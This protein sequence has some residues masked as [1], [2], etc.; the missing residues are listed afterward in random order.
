[1]PLVSCLMNVYNGEKYIRE[2]VDS[3]LNQT[4]SDFE[5]III[6]DGSTDQTLQILQSY[7]DSRIKVFKNGKNLGIS[8]SRNRG[9]KKVSGKYIA[10]LD[11]DDISL[12]HRFMTQLNYMENHPEIDVCGSAAEVFGNTSR[13]TEPLPTHDE[14][15]AGFLE[16]CRLLYSS[17]FIRRQTV[18]D[19]N[20]SFDTGFIFSEDYDFWVRLGLQ[21]AKFVNLKEVLVKYRWHDS[22]VSVR[23]HEQQKLDAIRARKHILNR[24]NINTQNKEAMHNSL[25]SGATADE[26]MMKDIGDWISELLKANKQAGLFPDEVLEKEIARMWFRVLSNSCKNGTG[27]W[28]EYHRHPVSLYF[29]MGPITKLKFYAK[30]LLKVN[31]KKELVERIQT[32]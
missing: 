2:A 13:I 4:F 5:F 29:P 1:M 25:Q 26:A 30:C 11:A 32:R 28:N 20:V 14:I 21:G 3:I 16:S 22:N 9:L 24:L 10:P 27:V 12:P 18:L 19:L 8:E 23:H 7:N 31:S 6:D 15:L 17:T